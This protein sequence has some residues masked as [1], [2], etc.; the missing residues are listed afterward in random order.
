[1]VHAF[2][3]EFEG[4][5]CFENLQDGGIVLFVQGLAGQLCEHCDI[6]VHVIVLHAQLVEFCCRAVGFIGIGPRFDEIMLKFIVGSEERWTG[7]R[8]GQNPDL[9]T[10]LPLIDSGAHQVCQGMRYSTRRVD[11]N[12]VC[13]IHKLVEFEF[14]NESVGGLSVSVEDEGFFPLKGFV[15]ES[16]CWDSWGSGNLW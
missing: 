12:Q 14:V 8:I 9:H 5:S 1:V 15:V 10:P 13:R 7:Y 4:E 3:K 2:L 16:S 6:G 11:H